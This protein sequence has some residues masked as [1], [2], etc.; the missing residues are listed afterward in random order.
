[1]VLSELKIKNEFSTLNS[2]I[3]RLS[4]IYADVPAYTPLAA[5]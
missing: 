2:K 5:A 1:M 4:S 3:S